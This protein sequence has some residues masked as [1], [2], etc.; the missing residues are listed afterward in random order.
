MFNFSILILR[1]FVGLFLYL[2][3]LGF[4]YFR[5]SFSYRCWFCLVSLVFQYWSIKIW[6]IEC[7]HVHVHC[8]LFFFTYDFFCLQFNLVLTVISWWCMI[9]LNFEIQQFTWIKIVCEWSFRENSRTLLIPHSG[10][11]KIIKW[12]N[13]RKMWKNCKL[14]KYWFSQYVLF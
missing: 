8:G 12:L 5:M 11:K 1:Y 3:M 9:L 7:L 14:E 4:F 10:K 6:S 2:K 13:L